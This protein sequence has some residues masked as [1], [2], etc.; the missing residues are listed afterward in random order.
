MAEII[1]TVVN[2]NL[3]LIGFKIKGKY[4]DIY[5]GSSTDKVEAHVALDALKERKFKNTQISFDANGNMMLLG[6]FRLYNLP[7]EIYMGGNYSQINNMVEATGRFEQNGKDVGYRITDASGKHHNLTTAQIANIASMSGI[8]KPKNFVV[9]HDS[10]NMPYLAAKVGSISQLPVLNAFAN[11]AAKGSDKRKVQKVDP[12]N[13]S[14]ESILTMIA[15]MNGFFAYIPGFIYKAYS[16][17]SAADKAANESIYAGQLAQPVIMP[18]IASANLDLQF[19]GITKVSVER[20][21]G[22]APIELYPQLFRVKSVYRSGKVALNTVGVVVEAKHVETLMT[23]LADASPF[24]IEDKSIVDYFARILA[25][26]PGQIRVV[27]ISLVGVKPYEHVTPVDYGRLASTINQYEQLSDA[28]KACNKVKTNALKSKGNKFA[29][30]HPAL[31]KFSEEELADIALAGVDIKNFTITRKPKEE[32][33]TATDAEQAK[34]VQDVKAVKFDWKVKLNDAA[35]AKKARD[36]EDLVNEANGYADSGDTDKL[37]NFVKGLDTAADT[38]KRYIWEVNKSITSY[39]EGKIVLKP[40]ANGIVM[41]D[42]TT[43]RMTKSKAASAAVKAVGIEELRLV[44][45]NAAGYEFV[46]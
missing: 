40:D 8:M 34:A 6:A 22:D 17:Q 11:Q 45:N 19:R 24:L 28:L 5:G 12:S 3:M 41:A 10:N 38:F 9:K 35:E 13:L 39:G 14:F 42:A 32:D 1:G 31:A 2:G 25:K 46:F 36:I 15:T 7:M 16:K 23:S 30:V 29:E 43:P 18:V 27:G 21:N 37:I 44:V 20:S 33:N 26:T 4:K